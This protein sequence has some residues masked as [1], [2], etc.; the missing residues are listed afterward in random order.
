LQCLSDYKQGESGRSTGLLIEDSMLLARSVVLV[1]RE[2]I[3]RYIQ[4]VPDLGQLPDM[5]RAFKR[6]ARLAEGK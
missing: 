6:A 3:V 4:L 2:G 5:D 1:D